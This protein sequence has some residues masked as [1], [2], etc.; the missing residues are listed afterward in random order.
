MMR[1]CERQRNSIECGNEYV[2]QINDP[3][4]YSQVPVGWHVAEPMVM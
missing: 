2:F 1:A 3:N 4:A